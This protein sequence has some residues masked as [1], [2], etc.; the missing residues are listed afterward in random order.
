MDKKVK[1]AGY[2]KRIFFNDNIEYR[3]FSPDLVGLQLT[4]K[5]GTTLF[6]NGNFSI[7]T[8]LDPKPDVVFTQG[9]RS[10][11][12]TLDDV[13]LNDSEVIIQKNVRTSLNLDYTNPLSYVWY[14]S[15]KE[16]IR[17]SL[18]NLEERFPAAIYV[19]NKVGSVTGNNITNYTY[20]ISLDESTFTVNSRFFI[21]PFSIKYTLDAAYLNTNNG[22][23]NVNTDSTNTLRN[24][25]LEYKN[26]VIEHNGIIK[27]IKS[28]SAATQQTNS[29]VIIVVD[30]NPFPELTGIYIPQYSFLSTS[31]DGSIPYFIKPKEEK[32]E[33]FFTSLNNFQKNILSRD[34]YPKY[35][36]NFIFN[37]ITD[38]G[39]IL[40]SKET[41]TFP[42]LDDGY[43][44]NFFNTF[45]LT[46]LNKITLIGENLDSTNTDII[47]RKYTSEAINSFDTLPKGDGDDYTVNGEKATKLLRIYGVGFDEVKKY[48][49]GIKFAHV[50]TYDKKN[51]VPDSLVKD[52]SYML[53]LD[54]ITFVT[55]ITLNKTFL[56]SNGDGMFSGTS[57]NM[58]QSEIDIEL[59][60]RLI[61][62][63]A[64]LWKSKGSRKAIEFLFRFI[65]APESL[66]NFNEY[67]VVVDKPLDMDRIKQ[68]LYLYTGDV[69]VSNIPYDDEGFPVPPINGELVIT[70]LVNGTSG[71][72]GV[73]ENQYT[74]MYFQKGGGW[75]RS[76]YGSNSPSILGG[77]NPHIGPYDSGNE[78]LNYFSRCFVPNFNSDPTVTLTSTTISKNYFKN[79]NNGIFNGV[80]KNTNN[81]YT[82]Q[83][84]FN[85]SINTYQPINDCFDINYEIIESP[86]QEGGKTTFE[87]QYERAKLEYDNYLEL[88]KK[89]NYLSYSPEWEIIKN[90]YNNSLYNLNLETSTVNCDIN[91]SLQICINEK[92]RK[93]FG[94]DCN[95]Y[96]VVNNLPFLYFVDDNN[97]KVT[98]EEF[99]SCCVNNGGKFISYTSED[100][101]TVQ[102]CSKSA[103]CVG[104][105]LYTLENGIVV[106]QTNT[107]TTPSNIYTING[108]CYQVTDYGYNLT[109]SE[110]KKIIDSVTSKSITTTNKDF[111]T[112]FK[113]V[114]CNTT[115]VSSP[116]CCAWYGYDTE[117]VY[118][119]DKEYIVCLDKDSI[120]VVNTIDDI[121]K[122]IEELTKRKNQLINYIKRTDITLTDKANA[123]TEIET[124]DVD[125]VTLEKEK[126]SIIA[127]VPYVPNVKGGVNTSYLQLQ[128]PA[129]SVNQYYSVG[130]YSKPFNESKIILGSV[131]N[132]GDCVKVTP[133]AIFSDPSLMDPINWKVYTIDQYGRVSF[134]PK[135][136]QNDYILDWNSENQLANL[137]KD[138]ANLNGY[139]FGSFYV[140]TT[141]NSLIP[142]TDNG[143]LNPSNPNSI[144]TAAV[145]P[146]RIGCGSLNDVSIVFG[147][148]NWS[149][150]KLPEITDCS[151]TVDISFDYMIKYDGEKLKECSESEK[152]TCSPAIFN[153]VTFTESLNCLNF[154]AFPKESKD[155]LKLETN[156]F[157]SGKSDDE[158]YEIWYGTNFD[159]PETECCTALTGV[160]VPKEQIES[161]NKTWNKELKNYY[162]QLITTPTTTFLSG[163]G[164]NYNDILNL[165]NEMVN[166]YSSV[167]NIV[168]N[169]N[170][171]YI[172]NR[173][174]VSC[175]INY[176]KLIRTNNICALNLP[177]ECG[178]WTN[179]YWDYKS[180][181]DAITKL[182]NEF[183][184]KCSQATDDANNSSYDLAKLKREREELIANSQKALND[185]LLQKASLNLLITQVNNEIIQK[186]NENLSIN[187]VQTNIQQPLDCTV[188]QNKL[189]ELN[190]FDVSNYCK[191]N[192]NTSSYSDKINSITEYN[193]CVSSKNLE[194]EQQKI[195]YNRLLQDCLSNNVLNDTLTVS[196]NENNSTMETIAQHQLED[197]QQNIDNTTKEAS[198]FIGTDASLQN[199][200]LAQNNYVKTVD[201]A[202]AILN[203]DPSTLIA[204]DGTVSLTDR[205]TLTLNITFS[206]NGKQLDDLRNTLDQYLAQLAA[207]E[208]EERKLRAELA[209]LES[210]YQYELN[211]IPD[212]CETDIVRQNPCCD[213]TLL[214]LL[215]DSLRKLS[216]NLQKVENLAK[217]CYT[218]WYNEINTSFNE[219]VDNKESYL[220]FFNDLEINFKLFVDNNNV[221]TF[222]SVD[223]NLTYLPYTESVNPIWD[224]N[225]T[226]GYTGIIL[227]GDDQIISSIKQSI[228]NDLSN[229][230]QPYNSNMFEP[231][232]F[233]FKYSIPECVCDDLRRLYP[234]KQFFFSIEIQNYKCSVCLLV[235]NII[236]NVSDCKTDRIITLNDCLIPQLSSVIDN[237]KSWV[238]YD[239]GVYKET[240]YPNGE[241]NVNS[242]VNYEILKITSPEERT[243]TDLEYRYTNYNEYHS[244]LVINV[245][246]ASFSIDPAKAIE[247][248]VFNYWRNIDCDNCPTS[249]SDDSKVFEDDDDFLFMDDNCYIFED[250]ST[251]YP[252]IFNGNVYDSGNTLTSYSLTFEDVVTT[253][254]TFDCD[255]YVNILESQ[256]IELK[257]RYYTLTAD[258]TE[259]LNSTYYDLLDKGGDL[260]LFYIESN[261][262]GS[263]T[264]VINNNE[265][266]GNQFLVIGENNDGTISAF[267]TYLYSGTTP[268][269]GGIVKDVLS[270]ITAQTY[271][272]TLDID[273]E[274]CSSFNKFLNGEGSTGLG[275]G[276]N[277]VWDNGTNR[278]YWKPIS[279]CDKCKGDCEFC[280]TLTNNC[281][282]GTTSSVCINPLDF[283]DIKPSDIGVKDT[284]DQLILSNLID[285]KS[286][287]TI[288][289]YPLLWLFY[290]L[291]LNA[292]NCGESLSGHLTYDSLFEFM[293]KIGDYWLGL[294]EQVVPSTTIWE[295]FDNS[296]KIYR[297]TIF[298]Q[299][300]FSYKK[301]S[302]NLNDSSNCSITGVTDY[303]IGSSNV[304]S[305]VEQVPI[306]P[307]NQKIRSIKVDI[308]NKKL[309]IS[310]VT[311]NINNLN[312]QMCSLD[313]QD[314]STPNLQTKKDNLNNAIVIANNNLTNL[315]QQLNTLNTDLSVE[316]KKYLDSQKNYMDNYM[317]C[318]GITKVMI[319]AQND[320]SKYTEGTTAYEKQRNYIS[321]LKDR[322]DKC[323]LQSNALVSKYDQVFIT[324]IFDTNE[325]EGNVT[326]IGDKDWEIGGPFY[327][328]EMIHNCTQ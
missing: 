240:I 288:S 77:N 93:T 231:N 10:K 181:I 214:T 155:V 272:Q 318:T 37:E 27:S 149:G 239:S 207:L 135:T 295:G 136:F 194:I 296:G 138:I 148:E 168:V 242:G 215:E 262:C 184:V 311:K 3:N 208:E 289:G 176:S 249:C 130:M 57:T 306:Y 256:V 28:F 298:D 297:N 313:L 303:S 7:E 193:D 260:P 325:Y 273:S 266:V 17:A 69:D 99:P 63:I 134:I 87:Q 198:K 173:E 133:N 61:L 265:N 301:Y 68:L 102:Y 278:C 277:Y 59:Y 16:L 284:F 139:T 1:I 275:L 326:I 51:N 118:D 41:L 282:S 141:T 150:F 294:I 299:N 221:N 62:N 287:Q 269:S 119:G 300:K 216:N 31:Y 281:Q 101:K 309:Q 204:D 171:C 229:L 81:F 32:Q 129:G 6:T 121:N 128:N 159:E 164:F 191:S 84:T 200:Q 166:I 188:Y 196:K 209:D 66:V 113:E 234:N 219:Y 212:T 44:L 321:I 220:N 232:W 316:E 76:T 52:L 292:S 293:D 247:C 152:E 97:I 246:N 85:P 40:T 108:K 29:D 58:T 228:F 192:L 310:V 238:Y 317:S 224:F 92:P 20:D 174:E 179:L 120:T 154:I 45:Y 79:Y 36:A 5:G 95:S 123:Q 117:K 162:T 257:N 290:D 195:L 163:L 24:L 12:Y 252:I 89:D 104:T 98:F 54:P 206:R 156:F 175:E 8:N 261:E 205:Q 172:L 14:G 250:Q 13:V 305:I 132:C 320:L 199:S 158:V 182:I 237:K 80:D 308:K 60:R 315:N 75:Y 115:M 88:I 314:V 116:E 165:S 236:V 46:Y 324:Q 169:G 244:D 22:S 71:Q 213:K 167:E 235:D 211:V 279:D 86:L 39:V 201:T 131:D 50:V 74:E 304:D 274:C 94:V 283:L 43:N 223:T 15:S 210:I 202:A 280:G 53:G 73:I 137:Y 153:E 91:Q 241:C 114:K 254:L 268:Y 251:T 267:E 90:N 248:D 145:D 197:V 33:E 83:L 271:N 226:T 56:P 106:F 302:L 146:N 187:T 126:I 222:N 19:D 151:C 100:C 227:D 125:I 124:I 233:T 190:N 18:I 142:F 189:Y 327:N 42:V 312:K 276:K 157:D 147:S 178:L 285:V 203:V 96:T 67:I 64:W 180:R 225:P 49:N 35:T 286:R 328:E 160:V 323:V 258:Y 186:E 26:Y 65:G 34:T 70:D 25:T 253:G 218:Q 143:N 140:D 112:Y 48:I 9:T 107:N 82:T 72:T 122:K 243:F 109:D 4:S 144:T 103:P 259:S 2:A 78:Y 110:R 319:T 161:T 111:T 30:G 23:G 47:V 170:G 105:P 307:D 38:E 245:K 177:L 263:E 185:I 291:Y 255:T 55:D 270:G 183:E 217:I 127:G 230:N 21:N 322:Y 264:I 11:F